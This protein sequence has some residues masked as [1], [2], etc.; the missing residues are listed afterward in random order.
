[1]NII[2]AVILGIVEGVTEFLPISSTGHLILVSELLKISQTDFVKTFEIA[3]QSGA[4]LAVILLFWKKF[5]TNIEILKRVIVAFIPTAV[6]G[7]VLYKIIKSFLLGNA[8][9]VLISLLVGGIALILIEM[10]FKNNNSKKDLDTAE[11]TY[12]RAFTIGVIQSLSVIPGVSRSAATIV[13]G[14]LVGLKREA[15]VEFSFLLAVPTVLAATALDLKETNFSF[16]SNEWMLLAVG[17]IVSFVVALLVIKWFIKYV[18]TNTFI[19]F[20]IYRIV[21]AV[22]Y[23]FLIIK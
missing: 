18:Q 22:L 19:P 1:M 16:T 5:I 4:I 15:A 13:G 14:M 17:F 20:G 2:Q 6:I 11:L 9:I 23:F 21:V 10:M 8:D 12:Q 3:I 7:F